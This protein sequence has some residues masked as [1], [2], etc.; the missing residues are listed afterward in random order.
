MKKHGEKGQF[1]KSTTE[2]FIEEATE[3]HNSKYIYN[4]VNY[5]SARDKVEIFC[6][7]HGYFLQSPQDHLAG[8]GCR[9]CKN[10]KLR[11]DRICSVDEFIRKAQLV[12]G[13]VYDYSLVEYKGAKTP[14]EIICTIHGVYL[15]TPDSH[16]HSCG[17]P[18]C[19]PFSGYT[20]TQWV[21][22]C[23]QRPSYVYLLH[24]CKTDEEFLK[25]GIT[26]NLK[27]RTKN[28]ISQGLSVTQLDIIE[29]VNPTESFDAE[30]MFFRSLK[31][32]KYK[33]NHY[34]YGNTEC[35]LNCFDVYE[36]FQK[37]KKGFKV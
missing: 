32:F 12:H 10:E 14:I 17:C 1:K 20:R 4:R 26:V 33:P 23:N 11:N 8:K 7:A 13:E 21:K 25:I 28:F 16:L 35:F 6:S 27:Q 15:Q 2:D 19:N 3:V 18:D 31:E 9:E 5:T 36:E 29:F 30:K 37:V 22:H 24:L 34:F